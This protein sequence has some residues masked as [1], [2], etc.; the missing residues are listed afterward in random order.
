MKK[1]TRPIGSMMGA[2][3]SLATPVANA[4]QVTVREPGRAFGAKETRV[5]RATHFDPKRSPSTF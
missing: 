2:C 5:A 4:L 1:M 3:G